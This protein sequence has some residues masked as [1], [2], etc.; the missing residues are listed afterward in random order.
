MT[1]FYRHKVLETQFKKNYSVLSQIAAIIKYEYNECTFEQTEEIKKTIIEQLN[2]AAKIKYEGKNSN[3]TIPPKDYKQYTF[4]GSE[5]NDN[6][7][8]NCLIGNKNYVAKWGPNYQATLNDGSFIGICSH[9]SSDAG[10]LITIDVNGMKSP[11][12]FGHDIWGFHLAKDTC[13]LEPTFTY[14]NFKEDEAGYGSNRDNVSVEKRCSLTDT[15]DSNGFYCAYYAMKNECPDN[16]GES[17][18]NC[19]PR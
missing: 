13:K 19:L 1:V 7:H 17:Y 18:W 12:R 5:A 14:R 11:N 2:A 16:S 4:T 9:P 10:T 6:L 15:S 3:N 8:M